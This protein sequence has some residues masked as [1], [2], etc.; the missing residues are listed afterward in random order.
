MPVRDVDNGEGGLYV[1]G[2]S[3]WE[4]SALSA[5][6]CCEPETVLKKKGLLKKRK[7]DYY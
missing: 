6:F 4:L 3:K 7:T 1:G 5:K 2:G